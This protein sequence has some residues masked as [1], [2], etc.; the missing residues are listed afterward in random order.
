MCGT[1]FRASHFSSAYTQCLLSEF[2]ELISRITILTMP[3]SAPSAHGIWLQIPVVSD[4]P[5]LGN[6]SVSVH[7]LGCLC[8]PSDYGTNLH[9]IYISYWGWSAGALKALQQIILWVLDAAD[10]QRI[11]IFWKTKLQLWCDGWSTVDWCVVSVYI[12][13]TEYVRFWSTFTSQ[14][15][16]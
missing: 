10:E 6:P 5:P 1:C 12:L 4:K 15:A 3:I 7:S 11:P 14:R 2:I 13:L 16:F 9:E 8:H